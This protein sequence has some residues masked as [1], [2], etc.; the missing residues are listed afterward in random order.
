MAAGMLQGPRQAP[1]CPDMCTR[2]SASRVHAPRLLNTCHHMGIRNIGWRRG[3]ARRDGSAHGLPADPANRGLSDPSRLDFAPT[4]GRFVETRDHRPR[5]GR[6]TVGARLGSELPL[7][8]TQFQLPPQTRSSEV[9]HATSI[10]Q[11]RRSSRAARRRVFVQRDAQSN[12]GSI[13]GSNVGRDR[14]SHHRCHLG[15]AGL[16]ERA[17]QRTC[18]VLWRW[19][20]NRRG[21]I[22]QHHAT[23]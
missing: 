2:G 22:D 16:R 8:A 14:G 17:G 19:R 21:H 13:R 20:R 1:E 9:R 15:G 10:P 3:R 5:F 23:C 7:A 4:V 18:R 6:R 11:P 12:P